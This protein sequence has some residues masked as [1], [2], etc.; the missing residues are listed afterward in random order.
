MRG[1]LWTRGCTRKV[2]HRVR[3]DVAREFDLIGDETTQELLVRPDGDGKHAYYDALAV[4]GGF[5]LL[6]GTLARVLDSG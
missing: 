2:L 4:N 3:S 6:R 5:Q 1:E